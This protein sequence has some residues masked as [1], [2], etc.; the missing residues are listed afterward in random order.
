MMSKDKMKQ[1]QAVLF[2]LDGTL[3][4]TALDLHAATNYVL[5]QY[6]KAPISIEQA[7]AITSNGASA[8]L[9]AGF[10]DSF[11]SYDLNTIR[12][13][14]LDYYHDNISVHTKPFSGVKE[15]INK[16]DELEIPWGIITNKPAELTRK[17][18]QQ[19]KELATCSI[20]LGADSLSEKKPHPMPLLY[21]AEYL[22][23]AAEH[24]LYVG[25]HDRDIEAGRRANMT[26]VSVAWGYFAAD[27]DPL[28]WQADHHIEEP[29]AICD[30]LN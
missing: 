21:A 28:D 20:M 30:L 23:V 2:D 24:C 10:G 27:E 9:Q 19:Q 4:D 15:L 26:T 12:Q 25:D 29:L 11:H 5:K 22:K 3:L 6:N 7:R 8:L 16:L 18:L 1:Y 17:L 14:L 13:A